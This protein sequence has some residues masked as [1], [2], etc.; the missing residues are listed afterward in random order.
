MKKRN[1]QIEGLRGLSILI[2]V[3]YHCVCRYRELFMNSSIVWMKDWG[4]FG[5]GIFLMISCWFMCAGPNFRFTDFLKKRLVKLY[6]M[7][8]VSVILIFIITAILILPG[9]S[10]GVKDLL[11]NLF[12]VN[13]FIG[14]PY[15]D[16]AHWYMTTLISLT[17][18]MGLLALIKQQD[19]PFAFIIWGILIEGLYIFRL[20]I[21]GHALGGGYVG[22]CL[23][24]VSLKKLL[25][26]KSEAAP[27]VK[28][29]ASATPAPAAKGGASATPAPAVK[30]GAKP[31]IYNLLWIA[32]ALEGILLIYL[33]VG[34][35][36]AL[37]MVLI[38]PLFLLCAFEKLTF[39]ANKAFCFIGLISYPLYLTHQNIS[40]EIEYYLTRAIG[41]Y[42]VLYSLIAVIFSVGLAFGL[43]F[44]ESKIKGRKDK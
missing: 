15:V 35:I 5:V 31:V 42:S 7:Y 43:Y 30:G 25:A 6:P 34:K 22:Y 4:S 14:T 33:I 24:A 37:E 26:S 40:Y 19:K 44:A 27:A 20:D 8:A 12:F 36:P 17:V 18:I 32:A 39:M 23:V 9:R 29:D 3:I 11:L 13:G 28:G 16:G 41:S 2:I 1:M 10:S 38:I 21:F